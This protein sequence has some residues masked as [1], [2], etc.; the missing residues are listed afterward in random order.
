MVSGAMGTERGIDTRTGIDRATFVRDYLRPQ[1]PVVLTDAL[2]RWPA[3]VR[4]TP[5]SLRARFSERRLVIGGALMGFGDFIDRVLAADP[6]RPAPYLNQEPIARHLPELLADLKPLPWCVQPNW[7]PG[8]HPNRFIDHWFNLS[9]EPEL[10]I[11]AAGGGLHQLHYDFLHFNAFSM[12]VYG[13]K[14]FFLFPPEQ[15][16]LVYAASNISDVDDILAPDLRRF[17]LFAQA[18]PLVH[19]LEPGQLLFIPPGWWHDTRML[20]H[21]ISVSLNTAC[22]ANWAQVRRDVCRLAT[23]G[24]RPLAWAYL[25]LLGWCRGWTRG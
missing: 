4:W 22:R 21:S 25:T 24:R 14:R 1:R 5:Q 12:Q 19:D 7:L 23:G 10:F 9:A 18:Q 13:T 2:A 16:R 3:L 15:G 20:T 6:A 17:P 11:G 8:R